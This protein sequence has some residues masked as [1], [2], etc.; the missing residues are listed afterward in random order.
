MYWSDCITWDAKQVTKYLYLIVLFL[1]K[2]NLL[3]K[4]L[5]WVPYIYLSFSRLELLWFTQ[6]SLP[7]IFWV[8]IFLRQKLFTAVEII[9]KFAFAKYVFF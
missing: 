8:P 2:L 7:F 3:I 9:L 4:L 6:K 5:S 1:V